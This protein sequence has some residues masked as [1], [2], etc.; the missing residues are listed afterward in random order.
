MIVQCDRCGTRYNLDDAKV[1]PGETKVRC[2]RCQYVFTIPH[3]LTLDE[4]E[5]FGETVQEVED[6]FMKEW[7]KE[8]PS[9]PSPGPRQSA[10]EQAPPPRV[11]V[12][13]TAEKELFKEVAPSRVSTAQ[14]LPGQRQPAPP[15]PE[16]APPPRAFVPPNAEEELF[17]EDAH[18]EEK[19]SPEEEV[20]PFKISP[21]IEAPMKKER[22]ISTSF[23]LTVLLLV[24]VTVALYYWSKMGRP[25]PA[26]EY[27]YEQIYTLM[28]GQKDQQLFL[29]YLKGSEHIVEGGKVFAIQGKVA[30]R[31]QETKGFVKVKGSLFDKAGRVV[32]TST[33]YC[34]ITMT[35]DEV[36]NSSYD[37]LKSSFGFVAVGQARPVPPQQSLPFTI[38][39]FSPPEGATQY[40]VEIDEAAESG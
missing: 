40:Q 24:I 30:N 37:A 5:I 12:P 14:P 19:S 26:F 23:L 28:E 1:R 25:I 38:I 34:G 33:G 21:V 29:L 9:Q 31:S 4:Q 8:F 18:T 15:A 11:F 7:A 6:A 39:F 3:P 17:R 2:T 13:P 10:P 32:A 22:L 20:H 16:Q 27:I 35:D 36:K